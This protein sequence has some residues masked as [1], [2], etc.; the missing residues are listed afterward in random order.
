MRYLILC[1]LVL[2]MHCNKSEQP[3]P[4]EDTFYFPPVGS[5]EWETAS[6]ASLGWNEEAVGQLDDFVETTNTRALIILKNGRIAY[7]KYAG[8]TLTGNQPFGENSYWYWA[9][10]AKTLTSFLIGQLESEGKLSLDDPTSTYLGQGWSGLTTSQEQAITIKHQLT[11]TSGLDYTVSVPDCTDP[12]CLQYL[13][14]PGTAWYYHNAP[15]TLLDGVVEGASGMD[16]DTFFN[17]SLRDPIGMDGFWGYLD[18]NH[19]FY[20]PPRSMARYGLMI[21]ANGTW[22]GAPI[23][24]NESYFNAMTN[25]SQELNPSYGYLWWLN[26]KGSFIPPGLSFNINADITPKAPDE[27][28]AAMGR[29]GQLINIVPSQQLVVVRMGDDPDTSLVPFTFQDLMWEKL[30]A[31]ISE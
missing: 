17:Q 18:Y 3:V 6:I 2:F 29:N 23:L 24:G 19:I 11:M 4:E 5:S 28:F 15:Y 22:D 26:G 27:M 21:L 25:T 8:I 31:L 14:P 30:N 7:E 12:E 16:F 20:S 9:S 1:S 13:N 10:A